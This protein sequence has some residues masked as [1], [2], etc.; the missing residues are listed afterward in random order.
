M[1]AA[2]LKGGPRVMLGGQAGDLTGNASDHGRELRAG[3]E[4]T[5]PSRAGKVNRRHM[6]K[7]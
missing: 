4:G 7:T 2:T 1:A 6:V 5:G 3:G